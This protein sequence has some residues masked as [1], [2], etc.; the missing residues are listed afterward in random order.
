[1]GYLQMHPFCVSQFTIVFVGNSMTLISK[2]VDIAHSKAIVRIIEVV[3]MEVQG[4]IEK[5][6]IVAKI[7]DHEAEMVAEMKMSIETQIILMRNTKLLKSDFYP[8]FSQ[9]LWTSKQK[10]AAIIK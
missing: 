7:I 9:A 3:T 4:V 6:F 2:V 8:Y 5:V 1:M 10:T